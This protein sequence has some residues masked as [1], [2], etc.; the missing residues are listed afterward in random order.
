[1]AADSDSTI[2]LID[3]I[4]LTDLAEGAGTVAS[5]LA[6]GVSGGLGWVTGSG[7]PSGIT[8][9]GG[10]GL[11]MDMA[12]P[13][14]PTATFIVTLIPDT[15][16]QMAIPIRLRNRTVRTSKAIRMATGLRQ[17]DR[18]HRPRQIPGA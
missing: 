17:T 13:F 2:D 3:S 8:R 1:M 11:R 14:I 16:L 6:A 5:D 18:A 15:T 12:I 7:I 9:G 4:G 10:L